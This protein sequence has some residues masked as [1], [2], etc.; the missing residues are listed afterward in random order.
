MSNRILHFAE[1][2]FVFYVSKPLVLPFLDFLDF[3]KN[4]FEQGPLHEIVNN[5]VEQ[6]PKDS[7]VT[8]PDE[9]SMPGIARTSVLITKTDLDSLVLYCFYIFSRCDVT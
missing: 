1:D 5:L 9:D 7:E 4:L 3:S 8:L 2:N 6:L